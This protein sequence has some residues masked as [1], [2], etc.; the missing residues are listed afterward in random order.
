M[1]LYIYRVLLYDFNTI[2]LVKDYVP[3]YRSREHILNPVLE[4][5]LFAWYLIFNSIILY[6]TQS[7]IQTNV[8]AQITSRISSNQI[9]DRI[10]NRITHRISSHITDRISHV[11][12]QNHNCNT[13]LTLP[14][15][16]CQHYSPSKSLLPAGQR[17][18][19]AIGDVNPTRK[20]MPVIVYA[21]PCTIPGRTE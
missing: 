14:E 11:P 3:H 18:H 6:V 19:L 2:P 8:K 15:R 9:T 16:S 21:I 1:A 13:A 7:N 10:S 20:Q 4:S 17:E 5:T 12:S